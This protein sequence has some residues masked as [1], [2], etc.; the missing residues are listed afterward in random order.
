MTKIR[1]IKVLKGICDRPK[2]EVSVCY[3]A[4]KSWCG[5]FQG[6]QKVNKINKKNAQF[7]LIYHK[8]LEFRL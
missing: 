5:S 7:I 6:P 3:K 2:I 1:L 4:I 8:N